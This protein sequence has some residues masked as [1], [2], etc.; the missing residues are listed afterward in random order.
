LPKAGTTIT[1]LNQNKKVKWSI[2]DGLVHIDLP[3]TDENIALA[4]EFKPEK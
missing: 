3:K 2:K 1:L 4:F